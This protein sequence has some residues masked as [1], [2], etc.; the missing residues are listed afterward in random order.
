MDTLNRWRRRFVA[1]LVTLH[2][3][4]VTLYALPRPPTLDPATLEEPEVK[5]ELLTSARA[6]HSLLPWR[7]T[8][9]EQLEDLLA[10]ARAYTT[11]TDRA[12]DLVTPYLRFVD[13]TQSWHMF[14]GTPPRYP[15]ILAVEVST[16]A[17][18]E[19]VLYQDLNWGTGDSSAMNFRHRKVHENLAFWE[20]SASWDAYA[21]YWARR[22]D[23]EN[24]NRQAASVRLSLTRL[25]TP[26]PEQVR[27][28]DTD[29]KPEHGRQ[30]HVWVRP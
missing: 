9:E 26:S 8:A 30:P 6:I 27:N 2:L 11:A 7:D 23:D 24:P 13:S 16:T 29:R 25:T 5:T 3:A 20:R 21:A 1:L 15:L 28:G 22:W 14:G 18:S 17:E 4:C 10:V 12:R 19:Y